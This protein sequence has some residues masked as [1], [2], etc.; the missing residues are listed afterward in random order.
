MDAL[1]LL[2]PVASHRF[3]VTIDGEHIGTFTE[4]RGLGAQ[5][6]MQA[7]KEGGQNGFTLQ[8][9]G[10]LSFTPITLTRAIETVSGSLAGWFTAYQSN[11]G[12]GKTGAIT[13]YNG[14]GVQVVQWNLID[15]FPSRWT[16]PTFGI[17]SFSVVKET[18]ELVHNGFS[19]G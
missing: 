1:A 9:P 11:P 18:L 2:D 8:I 3:D 16:G 17:D 4:C 12:G 6:E 10:R 7:Y 19:A 13:A 14:L 15:V 5:I